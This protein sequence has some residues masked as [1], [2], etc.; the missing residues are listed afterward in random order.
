MFIKALLATACLAVIALCGVFITRQ[1]GFD[2]NQPAGWGDVLTLISILS[3][4]LIASLG[5]LYA[6]NQ[7]KKERERIAYAHAKTLFREFEVC[8]TPAICALHSYMETEQRAPIL[9]E[10][11]K[12]SWVLIKSVLRTCPKDLIKF[13]EANLLYHHQDNLGDSATYVIISLQRL[14][15]TGTSFVDDFSYAI[16]NFNE[17]ERS[18]DEINEIYAVLYVFMSVLAEFLG[19]LEKY[20]TSLE[21]INYR[22]LHAEEMLANLTKTAIETIRAP[23]KTIE[24]YGPIELFSALDDHFDSKLNDL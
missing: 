14:E 20:R 3:A 23:K 22:Q 6:E 16:E 2:S 7:S 5:L 4:G 21:S 11:F 10:F 17:K 19:N 18:A 15:Y 24:T 1:I 8:H 12:E 13:R 9:S